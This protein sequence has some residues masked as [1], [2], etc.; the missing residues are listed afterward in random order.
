MLSHYNPGL[1]SIWSIVK[2]GITLWKGPKP[3]IYN[4]PDVWNP[5]LDTPDGH[6]DVL[7]I[8]KNGIDF[9][10]N[11]TQQEAIMGARRPACCHVK[12]QKAVISGLIPGKGWY[13]ST[14]NAPDNC[15]GTW[16]SFCGWSTNNHCL[17]YGHN[18]D[19]GGLLFDSFSGWL[20]VNLEKVKHG[21]VFI[22][23][24]N[25]IRPNANKAMEGW[26]CKMV[27]WTV[28]K[29]LEEEQKGEPS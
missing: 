9:I 22:W 5:N 17:L 16:N 15:D 20:I 18:D 24:Q 27:Q 6:I 29:Q 14:K 2:K 1:N 3:N 21:L 11:C 4:P 19:H 7:N 28:Q 8:I 13:V 12:E 26:K 23:V 25:W 10:P